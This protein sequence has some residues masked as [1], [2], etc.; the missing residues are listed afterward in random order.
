MTGLSLFQKNLLFLETA[1]PDLGALARRISGDMLTRAVVDETGLAVDIDLGAGRLYNRPAV[2]F[3]REQV[4]SWVKQPNRVVVNCPDPET[5]VDPSTRILSIR[6]S[7]ASAGGLHKVPDAGQSGLLVIIGLGLGAHVSELLAGMA[8]RH[9]VLIEPMEE[10]AVQ[11]LHAIDWQTV[12]ERCTTTGASLHV[13]VNPDPRAVQTELEALITQFGASCMDGAYSFMHY[14]TDA[15]RAIA[16]GFQELA[17]MKS[18]LQGYYD[19]EKLMIENTVA[20]VS[21]DEFWVVDGAFQALHDLPAFIVGSGPSLDGSLDTIREWQ[22]HAVIFSAGSAL[23]SLLAAGITPDFQIEKENNE[24]TE[25]RVAHIF[26]QCVT[27]QTT[28]GTSLIASTTVK[29][30]VVKL[31]DDAFLFHREALSSTH[32]FG[33]GIN[34]VVGTGPFSANTAVAAASVFGFRRMYMFGCD[35]GSVDQATHH[36]RNTVYHTLDGHPSGHA[37]VPVAVPANFGGQ[38]WSNPYF[39]WSRWVFES[40]ITQ[41]G[42]DAVNCSDGIAITGARAVRPEALL[43]QGGQIDKAK[44]L[45]SLKSNC[46]Y[47]APGTYLENQN[48]SG[49]IE[50]WHEFRHNVNAFLDGEIPQMHSLDAFEQTLG[51][52]LADCE[53]RFGGAV[54]LLRGSMRSMIPVAGYFINRAPD[55]DSHR[56]LLTTFYD[57]YRAQI[58]RMLEDGSALLNDVDAMHGSTPLRHATG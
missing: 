16:R 44:L 1:F 39:L 15:T 34:P 13:I 49:A 56:L 20:N 9:V 50:K 25:E 48:V 23:Q 58:E 53:N 36:A 5:F 55:A 22:D 10:F 6:M 18:I 52:F 28:F 2:E 19:D 45:Q 8:P 42:I 14:Q 27:G 46:Q 30:S 4:L 37:D 12:Q 3:A 32:M 54:I 31:F 26:R 35:C 11:S 41:A 17:G 7:E 29:P 47:Q 51:R 40:M 21:D 57:V 38:A 43:V 33:A 24:T